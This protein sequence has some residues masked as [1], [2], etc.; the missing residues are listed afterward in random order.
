MEIFKDTR[1]KVVF[2]KGDPDLE[3]QYVAMQSTLPR[4]R[5]RQSRFDDRED[6]GRTVVS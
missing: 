6:G 1:E 3:F 2:V 5:Y 4:A